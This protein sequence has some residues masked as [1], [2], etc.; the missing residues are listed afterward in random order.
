[1][2]AGELK[3]KKRQ[4]FND[5]ETS[6]EGHNKNHISCGPVKFPMQLAKDPKKTTITQ[7]GQRMG[8]CAFV[9][10]AKQEKKNS[11][12]RLRLEH[13]ISKGNSLSSSFAYLLNKYM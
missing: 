6:K 12:T 10:S 1:M 11:S 9:D 7:N 2:P 4:F 8:E 5:P 13:K 3:Q